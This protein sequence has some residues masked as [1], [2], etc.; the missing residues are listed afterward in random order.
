MS[1]LRRPKFIN[2]SDFEILSLPKIEYVTDHLGNKISL[3]I[4]D[5]EN[6]KVNDH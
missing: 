1:P 6:N 4:D 2:K 3:K 5:G